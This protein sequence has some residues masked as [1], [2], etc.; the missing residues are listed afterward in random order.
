[1]EEPSTAQTASR[2]ILFKRILMVLCIVLVADQVSKAIVIATIEEDQGYR[3]DTFFHFTHQRNDGLVGG[4][5]SG[6]RKVTYIAPLAATVVLIYLFRHLDPAS[7]FQAIAYGMIMGG[8]IGNFIDRLRLGSVTDFLQFHFYFIPFD[9]PWKYY[10]AFNVAD[11]CICV[12][13][14]VLVLSWNAGRRDDDTD[15]A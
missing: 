4:M 10:P 1:M 2:R 14:G 9:F 12:G 8:A 6:L 11:S 3:G 13:V 15:T 7:R 5:F